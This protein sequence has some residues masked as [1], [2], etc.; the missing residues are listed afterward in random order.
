[1]GTTFGYYR[2]QVDDDPAFGSPA[3]AVGSGVLTNKNVHEYI[4]SSDLNPN[5]IYY[6][7]ASSYN[8]DGEYSAWS[9][10]RTFRTA[11]APPTLLSPTN[12][13]G[14]TNKKPIFDWD[15]MAGASSY[16]LQISRNAVFTSLVGTY[17]VASS[18]YTPTANLT[19]GTLYWH[20]RANGLN[21]P[22]LWSSPIWSFTI[23]P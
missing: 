6:W 15:D 18:T 22:S 4:P 10:V 11:I 19:I 5:T 20:V 12:G 13:F 2:V 16:T 8:A 3:V 14:L 1:M 17:T 23:T 21:G 9:V 7:R